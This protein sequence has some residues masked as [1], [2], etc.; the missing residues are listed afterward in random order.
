[1]NECQP[2][3]MYETLMRLPLFNGVTYKHLSEIIGH[4]RLEFSKYSPG[5]RIVAAGEPCSSIMFVIGGSVRLTMRN[6]ADRFVVSQTIETPSVVLPDFL[7]GLNTRFPAE[8]TAVDTVSIMQI[9]KNDFISIIRSDEVCLFNYLNL[10][11]T[12]AQKSIDEVL[13]LPSGD[14]E[15]RIAYLFLALTQRDAKDITL[16]GVRN[17]HSI[18]GAQRVSLVRAL[19][20]MKALGVLD[21]DD[22]EIRVD[23]R[24]ALRSLLRLDGDRNGVDQLSD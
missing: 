21:Y 5:E 22:S 16:T 11:S 15:M 19:D 6:S 20:S 12:N 24:N 18:F 13:S 14:I 8:V 23:S 17:L 3:S 10:V 9:K 2:D 4:T 7:F 1:M